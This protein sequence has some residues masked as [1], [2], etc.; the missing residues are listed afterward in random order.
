MWGAI[1]SDP[2]RVVALVSRYLTNQLIRREPLSSRGRSPFPPQAI[3]P[4]EFM[5]Y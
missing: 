4:E 3:R 5:R 2:L 1:L